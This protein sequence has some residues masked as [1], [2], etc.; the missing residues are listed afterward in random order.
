MYVSESRTY[1][2]FLPMPINS[3]VAN[4]AYFNSITITS[5]LDYWKGFFPDKSQTHN[6]G[7]G[8]GA[9]SSM[10]ANN[11]SGSYTW[12]IEMTVNTNRYFIQFYYINGAYQITDIVP[13]N[14][15]D[16]L[17]IS[18]VWSE[19]PYSVDIYETLDLTESFESSGESTIDIYDSI[20]LIEDRVILFEGYDELNIFIDDDIYVS[21]S[22][23]FSTDGTSIDVYTEI[24]ITDYS[25][26]NLLIPDISLFDNLEML[27]VGISTQEQISTDV[28]SSISITEEVVSSTDISVDSWDGISMLDFP[29]L[30]NEINID[31][32]DLVSSTENFEYSSVIVIDVWDLVYSEETFEGVIEEVFLDIYDELTTTEDIETIG[33]TLMEVSIDEPIS[34]SEQFGRIFVTDIEVYDTLLMLDPSGYIDAEYDDVN[35]FYNDFFI[36]YDGINDSL[37]IDLELYVE[38]NVYSTVEMSEF[39][40]H[41]VYELFIEVNDSIDTT[42]N[43]SNVIDYAVDLFDEINLSDNFE[44]L[45]YLFVSVYEQINSSEYIETANE[46]SLSVHS[47][48]AISENIETGI[49]SFIVVTDTINLTDNFTLS[50]TL[51]VHKIETFEISEDNTNL[52]YLYVDLYDSLSLSE[53]FGKQLLMYIT[54]S[55]NLSIEEE[56]NLEKTYNIQV[57][58]TVTSFEEITLESFMFPP[59]LSSYV[60]A[61]TISGYSGIG[62][63]SGFAG[64]G[65]LGGFQGGIR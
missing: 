57:D 28:Y 39:V 36:S 53:N 22:V 42:D 15:S 59:S 12:W 60:G 7:G 48:V 49:N 64:T 20:N 38:P 65:A 25:E 23:E 3:F 30:Y 45:N 58:D 26:T 56:V 24:N 54:V 44:G 19:H 37:A 32:F 55:D 21:H 46:T 1:Q 4:V 52:L 35:V 27:D 50:G 13:I 43:F 2:R 17:N 14:T 61:S 18:D 33:I 31:V 16:T 51:F 9:V 62:V 10:S 63:T 8:V 5:V 40:D 34:I 11:P 41:F 29:E 6:V 47:S